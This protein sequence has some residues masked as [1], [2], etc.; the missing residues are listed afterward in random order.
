VKSLGDEVVVC[1]V[2]GLPEDEPGDCIKG[3]TVH[4]ATACDDTV[5]FTSESSHRSCG[6]QTSHMRR[7]SRHCWVSQ[8]VGW[9]ARQRMATGAATASAE[10][11]ELLEEAKTG[12]HRIAKC[13]DFQYL[14]VPGLF[15][16][17]YPR[18][19]HRTRDH[20]RELGLDCRIAQ[21]D[22]GK[23][24]G[25]NAAHLAELV[26][27]LHKE[28]G[29]R[30]V[31][32]GHSKGG[33][34]A[35]AAVSRHFENLGGV[36]AGIVCLQSPLGGTPIANDL[37]QSR[38]GGV[39]KTAIRR[40]FNG[41]IDALGDLT[42]ERRQ[43]ELEEFPFPYDDVP[44]VTLSSTT[45]RKTSLMALSRSYMQRRYDGLNNDGIVADVDAD[46]PHSIRVEL[47][48]DFDHG[49]CAFHDQFVNE[50]AVALLVCKVHARS[51]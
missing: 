34:D 48:M 14:I 28:C 9:I 12:V 2:T 17:K 1:D 30:I 33:C 32:I 21:V 51:L 10:F 29:K 43:L 7:H 31:L 18:Y 22:T 37:L 50:A 36:V 11:A 6:S 13:W 46:L 15:C 19:M 20:F 49:E 4:G 41:D 8:Q 44:V 27:S 38:V 25:D 5:S 39:T 42:Y 16:N 35:V 47:N 26:N 3:D 40:V 24:V 45:N 23:S